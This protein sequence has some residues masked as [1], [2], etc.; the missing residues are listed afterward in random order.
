MLAYRQNISLSVNREEATP[1][2]LLS[3]HSSKEQAISVGQGE[4]RKRCDGQIILTL[5]ICE[6]K[7]KGKR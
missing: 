3:R 6:T 7:N 1:G 5:N 2:Y 4:N